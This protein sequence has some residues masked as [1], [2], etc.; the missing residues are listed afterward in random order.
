MQGAKHER[1]TVA[2]ALAEALHH[3]AGP[4]EKVV[5][6]REGAE[7]V[8]REMH[9][10]LATSPGDAASATTCGGCAAGET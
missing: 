4:R 10:A 6:R 1:L 3:S 5:D 7:G 8:V 9:V 2:M